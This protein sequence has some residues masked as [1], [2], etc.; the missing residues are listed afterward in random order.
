MDG[1]HAIEG[2]TWDPD[3]VWL[4]EAPRVALLTGDET[5]QLRVR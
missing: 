3:Y 5:L 1:G 2:L 4:V